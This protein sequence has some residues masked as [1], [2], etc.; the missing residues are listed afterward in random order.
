LYLLLN[1]NIITL[2]FGRMDVGKLTPEQIRTL[3]KAALA[4]KH[5]CTVQYIRKILQG[6]HKINSERT[7]KIIKDIEDILKILERR[8]EID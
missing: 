7:L 4:K 2:N 8:T 5:K 6:T 1:A 3:P